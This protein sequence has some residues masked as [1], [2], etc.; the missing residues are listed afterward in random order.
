MRTP[1]VKDFLLSRDTA[2]EVDDRSDIF[3]SQQP[4]TA[5]HRILVFQHQWH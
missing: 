5:N 2:N 3:D 4:P 1:E